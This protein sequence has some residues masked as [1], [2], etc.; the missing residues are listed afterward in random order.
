VR[1]RLILSI[2]VLGVPCV[3]RAADAARLNG[4]LVA[5]CMREIGARFLDAAE[6][7]HLLI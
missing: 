7:A 3:A 1:S 4:D 5:E 2:L 6:P